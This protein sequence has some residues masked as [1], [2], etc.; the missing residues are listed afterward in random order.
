MCH[1]AAKVQGLNSDEGN[2]G[3]W[4]RTVE[5]DQENEHLI[6][7]E[8]NYFLVVCRLLFT[9]AAEMSLRVFSSPKYRICQMKLL[10]EK[11]NPNDARGVKRD[12]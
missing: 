10:K 2:E 8:P 1:C 5:L 3:F 9:T 7:K 4:T 6:K 11:E 12:P